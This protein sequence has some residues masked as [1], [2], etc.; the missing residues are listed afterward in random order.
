MRNL[1]GAKLP[2]R[3]SVSQTRLHW[4]DGVTVKQQ[5]SVFQVA[6]PLSL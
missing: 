2:D 3:L 1:K 5:K 6:Q 4:D